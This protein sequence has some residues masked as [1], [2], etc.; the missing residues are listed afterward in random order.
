MALML[1]PSAEDAS[2]TRR[3]VRR[4]EDASPI[5]QA[6]RRDL[7]LKAY[8]KGLGLQIDKKH[9]DA[10]YAFYASVQHLPTLAKA[11]GRL[12]NVATYLLRLMPKKTEQERKTI[13]KYQAM[14]SRSLDVLGAMDVTRSIV[15]LALLERRAARR[16]LADH[17]RS[18]RT[19]P[20]TWYRHS[21]TSAYE[22]Y[23]LRMRAAGKKPASSPFMRHAAD[24]VAKLAGR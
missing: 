7:A 21:A 15:E 18:S 20:A 11:H 14:A 1:D 2:D 6:E 17:C 4:L 3:T 5:N 9:V 19:M 23:L 8:N 12:L 16:D 22:H 10:L 24:R 13:R